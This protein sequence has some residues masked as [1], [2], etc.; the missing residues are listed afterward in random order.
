M[1]T[2]AETVEVEIPEELETR[3][4][5]HADLWRMTYGEAVLTLI[6]RGLTHFYCTEP[7]GEEIDNSG[8]M[9]QHGQDDS[10]RESDS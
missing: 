4:E 10:D 6:T 3:I 1:D 2:D 7:G 8:R 5:A 9:R